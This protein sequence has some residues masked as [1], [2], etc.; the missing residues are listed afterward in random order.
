MMGKHVSATLGWSDDS[1]GADRDALIYFARAS[2]GFG[3]LQKNALLLSSSIRGR[4]ESGEV[5]N[6]QLSVNARYYRTQSEKRL[7]FT[8]LRATAGQNLDLDNPVQLGGDTGLRGYPLRY[9]NGESK[10]LVTVEQRYFTDWYPFRLIRVGAAMFAD[11]GR[12]WGPSPVGEER[13]SWLADVG[14]GLRLAPQST[15][16]SFCW[17]PGAAS[18]G[19]G[20]DHESVRPA[21]GY[22]CPS[23]FH[24]T[25]DAAD[26][27]I[28]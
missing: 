25:T 12:V 9:Q 3:S 11:V 14:F 17:N 5:A 24:D 26:Q 10:L 23:E 8:S 7:F 4:L 1:F 20:L 2:R 16:Y 28:V 22:P 13:K 27:Q 19:A 15:T 6:A 21:R 18:R